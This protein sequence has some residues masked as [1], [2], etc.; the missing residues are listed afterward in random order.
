MDLERFLAITRA[1]MRC[2]LPASGD[3]PPGG[4]RQNPARPDAGN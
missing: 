3:T 4:A 2:K 1:A